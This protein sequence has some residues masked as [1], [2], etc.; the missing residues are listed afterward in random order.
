MPLTTVECFS[1]T[2]LYLS[3]LA[4]VRRGQGETLVLFYEKAQLA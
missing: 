3:V 4:Q 2:A 1:S